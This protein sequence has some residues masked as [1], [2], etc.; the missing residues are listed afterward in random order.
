MQM[1]RWGLREVVE[2]REGYRG[3]AEEVG[4]RQKVEGGCGP[5]AIT[6]LEEKRGHGGPRTQRS[7]GGRALLP[8]CFFP[9]QPVPEDMQSHLRHGA[10]GSFPL[11]ASSAVYPAFPVGLRGLRT[12]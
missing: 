6:K 10:R 2:G 3:M 4:S 11:A 7:W 12:R 9:L 5:E 8:F 1:R